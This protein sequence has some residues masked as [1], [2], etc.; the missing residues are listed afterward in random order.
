[1]QFG[2]VH[3]QRGKGKGYN[4]GKSGGKDHNKNKSRFHSYLEETAED[5]ST[6]YSYDMTGGR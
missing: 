1:M 6:E 2:D 5:E 4:Y 3:V